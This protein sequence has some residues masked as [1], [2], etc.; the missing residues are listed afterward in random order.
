MLNFENRISHVHAIVQLLTNHRT[1]YNLKQPVS[2]RM[3]TGCKMS[4]K[5]HIITS[6][7]FVDASIYTNLSLTGTLGT[8]YKLF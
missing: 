4:R 2:L 1:M 6:S 7:A 3:K 8:W 5:E